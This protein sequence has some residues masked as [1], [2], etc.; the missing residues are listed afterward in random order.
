MAKMETKLKFDLINN[1]KT[2]KTS[3][4]WIGGA[5]IAKGHPLI[6]LQWVGK[7]AFFVFDNPSSCEAIMEAFYRDDLHVRAQ[8]YSLSL[9]ALKD[10]IFNSKN[11]F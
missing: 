6:S 7:K 4:F 5:L 1:Q 10:Q 11:T 8:K 3:D 2:F 9:R